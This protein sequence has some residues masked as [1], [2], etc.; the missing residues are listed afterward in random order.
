MTQDMNMDA[1]QELRRRGTKQLSDK[2][3]FD[4]SE[5]EL[6]FSKT[7]KRFDAYAKVMQHNL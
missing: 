1:I 3:M 7:L 5:E 4:K 6:K 2:D